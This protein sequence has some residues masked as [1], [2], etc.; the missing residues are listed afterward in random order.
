M[1]ILY[2]ANDD[3]TA[4]AV[5]RI[6]AE[7]ECDALRA[8]SQEELRHSADRDGGPEAIVVQAQSDGCRSLELCRKLLSHRGQDRHRVFLLVPRADWTS[9]C[10]VPSSVAV[11]TLESLGEE[12][13]R[14]GCPSTLLNELAATQ[15]LRFNSEEELTAIFLHAPIPIFLVDGDGGVIR[16]NRAPVSL[17]PAHGRRSGTLGQ[18][19]G[20]VYSLSN[21]EGCGRTLDG[22]A[23]CTHCAIRAIIK[24][25]LYN[26]SCHHRREAEV[27]LSED[28]GEHIHVLVSAIPV[29]INSQKRV[30]VYL[31]DI[32]EL[33]SSQNDLEELNRN[34][35]MKVRQR[36]AEVHALL[37]QK[38]AFVNQLGHD[39]RTPL[40]PIIALLPLIREGVGE[41]RLREMVDQL[42]RN[43]EY[44]QMLVDKTLN[45][46]R[47]DSQ[48]KHLEPRRLD[49]RTETRNILADLGPLVHR[50]N[51]QVCN[52]I[53]EPLP[54][55]ADPLQV[56][57]LY[58]N[59]IGNAV[60]FVGD[61]GTI[62]LGGC[63]EDDW[64]VLWVRDTGIG[65]DPSHLEAIFEEFFKVDASRHD[66]RSP[67]LGLAICRR[68]VA[69]HG[70]RIWAQ[71][72]GTGL[73]TTFYFT[74]PPVPQ[75]QPEPCNGQ[76]QAL[77]AEQETQT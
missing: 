22:E 24:D 62:T 15:K 38:Q 11:C 4:E 2:L 12:L 8:R 18:I 55:H 45:L 74:L 1:L 59:L 77:P 7:N 35:E 3:A 54:V 70:G 72:E 44:M 9:R 66:R 48:G 67:G 63:R 51:V 28:P 36:T 75:G 41:N 27:Q 19:L 21:P 49:L 31:E 17:Q 33:R 13:R 61:D 16:T 73:G 58:Y 65:V 37:A 43:A 39:L 57:E 29:W 25:T 53:V 47:V 40:T 34:L 52:T 64:V 30:L 50:K 5:E 26:G 60:K 46:I 76:G 14:A 20:C 56:R 32:T 69:N 6:A 10:T 71:S 42:I 23:V 68:I